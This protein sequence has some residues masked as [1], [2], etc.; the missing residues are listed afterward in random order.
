MCIRCCCCVNLR[1]GGIMMGV[2]T[3]ILSI[4]SLVPMTLLL[5]YR[6]FFARVITHLV[7]EV[8][9]SDDDSATDRSF[10]FWEIIKEASNGKDENFPPEDNQQVQWLAMAML[11]FFI[12]S[13]IVL[14]IYAIC[15]GLLIYG[16]YK[17]K[18]WFLLPWIVCTIA[19]LVAYF[20]GMCMSLYLVGIQVI[21]VLLFFIALIEIAI[22]VYLW[23]CMVSLFQILGSPNWQNR[24]DW[25][26]KPRFSNGYDGVSTNED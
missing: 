8:S 7:Q 21:S 3:L 6:L 10:R 2:M 5:I 23:L 20:I 25:E 13:L 22:A 16:V 19:L 15:S 12:A 14:I 11:I 1:V 24:Q 4:S 17:A 26:L 9:Q 18:K